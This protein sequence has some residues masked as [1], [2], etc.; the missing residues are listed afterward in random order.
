MW[1]TDGWASLWQVVGSVLSYPII[2]TQTRPITV[3]ALIVVGLLVAVSFWMSR[4]AQ[5]I[6]QRRVFP[7]LHLDPGLEFSIARFVHYAVLTLGLLLG[8]KTL[9]VDLTGLAVVAGLLRVPSRLRLQNLA[10]DVISR[11]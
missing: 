4:R 3:T 11:S 10:R 1:T 5:G 7:R 9:H 6:L 8:L 2:P